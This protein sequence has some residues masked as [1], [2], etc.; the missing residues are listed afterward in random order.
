MNKH[1]FKMKLAGAEKFVGD[2][3][4]KQDVVSSFLLEH[5]ELHDT[6]ILVAWYG[7]GCY[8]GEAFVLF[9]RGGRLYEV[10]GGHCSCYGLEGQWDPEETSA[11]ALVHRIENGRLGR[12]SY[13]SD[14]DFGD[15]LVKLLKHW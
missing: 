3:D 1:L 4:C 13:Y 10:N 14:C 12:D 15:D 8:D 2:F 5:D 11:E 7:G 9:E 6:F